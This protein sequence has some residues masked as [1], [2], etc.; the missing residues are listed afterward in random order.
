VKNLS[1]HR[2]FKGPAGIKASFRPYYQHAWPDDLP[3]QC[4]EC[5]TAFRT[6]WNLDVVPNRFGRNMRKIAYYSFAP[7]LFLAFFVPSVFPSVAKLFD[8]LLVGWL[9]AILV[10]GPPLLAILTFF[11]PLRRHVECK[12][13]GWNKDYKPLKEETPTA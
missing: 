13:C 12:K 10:L 6:S 8:G 2:T 1:P 3:P 9:F 5:D 4:P 7:G 11:M